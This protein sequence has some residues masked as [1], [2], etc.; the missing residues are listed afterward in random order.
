[1]L[2][3]PAAQ[4]AGTQSYPVAPHSLEE[5][6]LSFDLLEQLVL[7]TLHFSGELSGSVLARKLGVQY[8]VIQPVLE[9]VKQLYLVEV[10][11]SGLLAG[12]AYIYRVTDA[13]RHRAQLFIEQSH[14][15]GIAPVPFAQY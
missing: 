14:Y 9:H 10:L 7:K 3:S 4:S 12:P 5:S 11:G 6:G 8:S 1:M 15:V 2:E 13:G